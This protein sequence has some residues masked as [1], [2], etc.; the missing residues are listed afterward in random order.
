MGPRSLLGEV[1]F[2]RTSLIG[3]MDLLLVLFK[4]KKKKRKYIFL[5]K[6]LPVLGPIPDELGR[7]PDCCFDFKNKVGQKVV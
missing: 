6:G 5:K 4:K 3:A 1:L 2:L 7:L